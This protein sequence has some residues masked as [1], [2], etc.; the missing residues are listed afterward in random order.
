MSDPIS[1]PAA[2]PQ[3][4]QAYYSVLELALFTPYTR[5]SYLAA[6]GQQAP[7]YDPSR[8]I[9]TWFDSSADTSAPA[10]VAVYKIIAQD[11]NG[12]WGFQQM[13]MPAT[14][15]ATVNLPGAI[16]YP[17]Y[18]VAP[19]Q[20]TRA[21][22]TMASTP[23]SPLSSPAGHLSVAQHASPRR[24]NRENLPRRCSRATCRKATRRHSLSPAHATCA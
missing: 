19:T 5:D 2:P 7:A 23:R 17:P 9:K 20:A 14:E 11:P 15:A 1:L 6:F 12:N 21:L 18:V 8:V 3:P 22:R 16:V 10:N 13:V 24:A 4:D